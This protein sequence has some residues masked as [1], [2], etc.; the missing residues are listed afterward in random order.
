MTTNDAQERQKTDGAML[1]GL[2]ATSRHFKYLDLSGQDLGGLDLSGCTFERCDL[3]GTNFY[4]EVDDIPQRCRLVNAIFSD[5]LIG[6][7]QGEP[8]WLGRASALGIQIVFSE[9]PLDGMPPSPE[10]PGTLFVLSA[11]ECDFC[12]AKITRAYFGGSHRDY[13]PSFQKARFTGAILTEC[14]LGNVD[15]TEADFGEVEIVRPVSVRGMRILSVHAETL[16]KQLVLA[17]PQHHDIF[18]ATLRHQ[19]PVF[20]LEQLGVVVVS[21]PLP[22]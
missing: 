2:L 10:E 18:R 16:A 19:G 11:Q 5:C 3:R 14:H 22:T 15:F 20:A 6:N 21:S 4:S 1:E 7:P 8:T 17:P 12:D 13:G 9:L